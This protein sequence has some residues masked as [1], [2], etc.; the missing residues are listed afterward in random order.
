[1]SLIPLN[2]ESLQEATTERS[3]QRGESYY[4]NGAVRNLIQRGQSLEAL[5][6]GSDYEPYFV[7]IEFEDNQ[8]CSALCSCP[9]DY[10]GWC[11]H[12]V[13]VLLAYLK[14]GDRLEQRLPLEDLLVGLDGGKLREVLIYLAQDEPK[15]VHKIEQYLH[16][17]HR[18]AA[19]PVS[20]E[21][22]ALPQITVDP[23]YYKNRIRDIISE[24]ARGYD[25]GEY[26]D[27]EDNVS[28]EIE[29]L[30]SEVK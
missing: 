23:S 24:T 8:V 9:Y 30:L 13:A 17:N 28:A 1:M 10:D 7:Q 3:W 20:G 14:A 27:E 19:I 21:Q 18:I 16:K 25:Y 29:N 4:Y 15:L 6:N 12:I 2:I 11:K 5:V 22:E 26:Y